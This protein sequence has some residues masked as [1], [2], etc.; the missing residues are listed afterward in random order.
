MSF[1]VGLLDHR[2]YVAVGGVVSTLR[3]LGLTAG[4][5]GVLEHKQ[6]K[7]VFILSIIDIHVTTYVDTYV[8]LGCYTV[9]SDLCR[10]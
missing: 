4:M 2:H 1:H 8:C 10:V 5:L 7:P 3:M 9:Q 6:D